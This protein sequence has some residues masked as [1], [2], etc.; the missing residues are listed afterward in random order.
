MQQR[1]VATALGHAVGR[2]AKVPTPAFV[3]K[4]SMGEMAVLVLD[5]QRCVAR[6]ATSFG[7]TWVHPDVD[8][9]LA[10]ALTD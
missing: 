2:P 1:D 5:S 8:A 10:A 7:Y 4:A 3:L 9:A 6:A